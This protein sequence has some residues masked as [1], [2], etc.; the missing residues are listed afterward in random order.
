M[1]DEVVESKP[2]ILL[3]RKEEQELRIYFFVG[4]RP[5]AF[6]PGQRSQSDKR[7]IY[8]T[9]FKLEDAFEL[10]KMKGEGFNLLFTAQ[11]PTVREFLH[12]LELE[13]LAHQALKEKPYVMKEKP[14]E[15][16]R[17]I[18]SPIQ[19]SFEKFRAGLLFCASEAD[20]IYQKP[21]DRETLKEIIAGL[22]YG[23]L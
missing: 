8:V 23:K 21:E 18:L 13:A 12:E 14:A 3:K 15:E 5:T 16:P 22:S 10:A 6:L 4:D 9:G 2:N 1:V 19:M 17:K 20:V 11:N 7:V